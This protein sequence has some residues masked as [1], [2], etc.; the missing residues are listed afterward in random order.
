VTRKH[1]HLTRRAI[2]LGLAATPLSAAAQDDASDEALQRKA[3]SEAILAREGVPFLASLPLLE[4]AAQA[5][6][7]GV[8]EIS[9]RICCLLMAAVK[10]AD[11]AQDVVDD[12]TLRWG[13]EAHY[14][15]AERAF[16]ADPAPDRQDSVQFAW[17]YEALW[18]LMWSIGRIDELGRPDRI[19]D[20]QR[21]V[22]LLRD[23]GPEQ[24]IAEARLRPIADILDANDLI[25]RYHWAVVDARLMGAEPP[26]GLDPGVVQER[27]YAFNWLTCYGD[28]AWDDV[29]TDT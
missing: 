16:V 25:Y 28:E 9:Y 3:R 15:P 19:V 4:T 23:A 17:R 14:S 1:P 5:R 22:R 29:S 27:H 13:L 21:V 20:V 7:R 2:G 6:L 12:Y 11:Q 24:L 10:G 18:P 26:A 8:S